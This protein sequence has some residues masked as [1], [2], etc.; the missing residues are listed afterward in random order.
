MSYL[1]RYLGIQ[2]CLFSN[3]LSNE[4]EKLGVM[5]S[6]Q[7]AAPREKKGSS[8][9]KDSRDVFI[10]GRVE[11]LQMNPR[12]C[13]EDVV[14]PKVSLDCA[15]VKGVGPWLQSMEPRRNKDSVT[16]TG[17]GQRRMVLLLT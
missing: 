14:C 8:S 7:E 10:L 16:D 5:S 9:G 3:T 17:P 12:N 11:I 15:P 6:G 2:S 4:G 1:G 13:I